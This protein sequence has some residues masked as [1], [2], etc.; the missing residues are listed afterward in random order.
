MQWKH[1]CWGT[2]GE[3]W[4]LGATGTTS[5]WTTWLWGWAYNSKNMTKW[6]LGSRQKV[7]I[8]K[9]YSMYIHRYLTL[10]VTT[11]TH[12]WHLLLLYLVSLSLRAQHL[13]LKLTRGRAVWHSWLSS[14]GIRGNRRT[15][16]PVSHEVACKKRTSGY[17]ILWDGKSKQTKI[18][19]IWI[20][21]STSVWLLV[22]FRILTFW[23]AGSY[24]L[25]LY[26]NW[27][28][29]SRMRGVGEWV[30][31]ATDWGW[32]RSAVVSGR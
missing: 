18:H 11:Q 23:L 27:H 30:G 2:A 7:H 13:G 26:S 15:K 24:T 28:L 14:L 17:I 8:L 29:A 3:V 10:H 31:D 12:H 6:N 25:A 20:H 4:L 9:R 22:S 21:T 16:W 5:A 32:L 1:T 19:L